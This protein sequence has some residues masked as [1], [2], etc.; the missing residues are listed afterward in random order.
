MSGRKLQAIGDGCQGIFPVAGAGIFRLLSRIVWWQQL[1][2]RRLRGLTQAQ[3]L[4]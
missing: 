1:E 2:T 4:E 3:K